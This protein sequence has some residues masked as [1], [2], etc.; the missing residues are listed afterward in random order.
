MRFFGEWFRA[1]DAAAGSGDSEEDPAEFM[2]PVG[3]WAEEAGDTCELFGIA[4][5]EER[6]GEAMPLLNDI[7]AA[8]SL[9]FDAL[10][11]KICL[12]DEPCSR[13]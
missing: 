4:N 1:G 8:D 13:R 5:L 9:H 10:K 3:E 12:E 6:Y 7:L 2:L 11:A